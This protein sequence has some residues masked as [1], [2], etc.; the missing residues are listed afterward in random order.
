MT[1]QVVSEYT[2]LVSSKAKSLAACLEFEMNEEKVSV[3]QQ[4]LFQRLSVASSTKTDGATQ[5]LFIYE[6]C[7]AALARE[8]RSCKK[9]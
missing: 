6:L 5:E 3:N 2:F 9:S 4:L 8:K 1:D 7:R